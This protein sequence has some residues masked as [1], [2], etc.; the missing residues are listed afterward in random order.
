M[1]GDKIIKTSVAQ[2]IDKLLHIKWMCLGDNRGHMFSSLQKTVK[3]SGTDV[4]KVKYIVKQVKE[5]MTTEEMKSRGSEQKKGASSRL[6]GGGGQGW[7]M[8]DEIE[9]MEEVK[10]KRRDRE[11]RARGG[12]WEESGSSKKERGGEHWD[13]D[14]MKDR[15]ER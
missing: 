4:K 13:E 11:S 6:M 3:E 1:T 9:G 8:R 2:K 14:T 10:D 15:E 7:D 5:I 12:E